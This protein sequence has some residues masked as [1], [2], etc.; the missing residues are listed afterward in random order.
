LLDCPND[1]LPVSDVEA[2]MVEGTQVVARQR[3]LE[4]A[5]QLTAGAG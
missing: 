3:L 4:V 5:T 2:R 1:C